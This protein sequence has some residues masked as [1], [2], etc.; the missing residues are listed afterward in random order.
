MRFTHV[1]IRNLIAEGPKTP[2]CVDALALTRLQL[3][4]LYSICLITQDPTAAADYVKN[5]WKDNYVRFLLAR[6]ECKNLPRFQAYINN[7]GCA[8]LSQLQQASGVTDAEKA[9]VEFE[10]LGTPLPAGMSQVKIKRFP[11]PM[12]VIEAV[13]D[14]DRKRMLMR[15]YPEYR[16]LCAFAHGSAQSSMFKT[17]FWE[18]SPLQRLIPESNRQNVF[19]KELVDAIFYSAFSVVQCTCELT[20]LYPSD[21]ELKRAAIEAWNLVIDSHLLGH[22][23]WDIRTKA[24]LGVI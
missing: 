24:L 13:V 8:V 6:Q 3:E 11:Q 22:V 7:Q 18:R 23:I 20:P 14:P 12:G 21:V 1:T 9:S 17:A 15:L 16:R 19:E 4:T 10:E 2:A 5:F